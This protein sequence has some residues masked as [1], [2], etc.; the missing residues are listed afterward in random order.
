M[1]DEEFQQAVKSLNLTASLNIRLF[2]LV[3]DA[4]NAIASGDKILWDGTVEA[5]KELNK[6]DLFTVLMA[7]LHAKV[8]DYGWSQDLSCV[9]SEIHDALSA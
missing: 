3:G 1:T 9:T 5:M 4:Y 6:A 8:C 7:E 2:K